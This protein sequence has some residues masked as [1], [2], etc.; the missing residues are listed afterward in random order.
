MKDETFK[1]QSNRNLL[2]RLLVLAKMQNFDLAT[3]MT[4]SLG[5]VPLFIVGHS[6]ALIVDGMALIQQ[7]KHTAPTFDDK[8]AK[9]TGKGSVRITIP[10]EEGGTKTLKLENVLCV[11]ELKTNLLS[12]SKCTRNNRVVVFDA[13]E[14]KV[15]FEDGSTL[16]RAERKS[17]LYF[18]GPIEESAA[19]VTELEI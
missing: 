14:A 8:P 2:T 6:S 11:P 5:P 7:M 9:I 19:V 15:I 4:N 16:F 12:T 13:H 3:L 10:D 17:N 18:V 1:L